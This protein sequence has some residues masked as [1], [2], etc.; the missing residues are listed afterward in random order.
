MQTFT[1]ERRILTAVSFLVFLAVW[2]TVSGCPEENNGSGDIIECQDTLVES[3]GYRYSVQGTPLTVLPGG[4]LDSHRN[5][6]N[7]NKWRIYPCPNY[8]MY[9][10]L[11]T[12]LTP[13]D[14]IQLNRNVYHGSTCSPH[15]VYFEFTSSR[16]VLVGL[17]DSNKSSSF[18][19]GT[20]CPASN[21]LLRLT[22]QL[23][24][25]KEVAEYA[26]SS[27]EAL[28]SLSYIS[29]AADVYIDSNPGKHVCKILHL[30]VDHCGFTYNK[31]CR[32]S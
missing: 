28:D 2:C 26:M 27:I 1:D 6:S 16:T 17:L 9:L 13:E 24:E 4:L 21:D 7:F 30:A 3:D 15:P 25:C 10:L 12:S 31:L 29:G 18:I 32:L 20:I 22:K 14:Y 8:K 19:I 5:Q 11:S 23:L